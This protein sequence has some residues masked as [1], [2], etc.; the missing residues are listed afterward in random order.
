MMNKEKKNYIRI[1]M[2][3][4]CLSDLYGKGKGL[5]DFKMR[6]ITH[7]M[8]LGLKQGLDQPQSPEADVESFI[9]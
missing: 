9:L 5:L 3:S 2:S 4:K 8:L 7:R 1:A 6:N